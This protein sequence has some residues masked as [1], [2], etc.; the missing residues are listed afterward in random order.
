MLEAQLI[1]LALVAIDILARALRLQRMVGVVGHHTTLMRCLRVN[2]IGDAACAL[3]PWRAGGEPARLAA[4]RH[5]GVPVRRGILAVTGETVQTWLIIACCGLSLM[6]F[7]GRAFWNS[8][9]AWVAG[10]GRIHGLAL[11]IALLVALLAAYLGRLALRRLR[12]VRASVPHEGRIRLSWSQLMGTL[13]LSFVSLLARVLILPVL[14]LTLREAPPFGQTAL[15]SFALLYS[16]L[17]LPAPA[18]AG[19]VD[20]GFLS[21]LRGGAAAWNLLVLWRIYTSGIGVVL[22]TGAALFLCGRGLRRRFF[23]VIPPAPEVLPLR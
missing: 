16:Q 18:G 23:R 19:F 5:A 8:C 13:P 3:T 1:C 4:L 14:V 22:G 11:G 7:F 20:L 2:L 6:A 9:A 10:F 17:L 12:L 21:T 15:S